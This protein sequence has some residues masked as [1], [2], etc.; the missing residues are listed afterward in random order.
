MELAVDFFAGVL[1]SFSLSRRWC[2]PLASVKSRS[3]ISSG[4]YPFDDPDCGHYPAAWKQKAGQNCLC[5]HTD[6][7]TWISYRHIKPEI[8]PDK[9]RSC[10]KNMAC[11]QLKKD[12][13]KTA[14]VF[15]SLATGLSVFLVLIA[16][17]E[18][19]GS[20]DHCIELH[21]CRYGDCQ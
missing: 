21:G 6:G 7:G 1:T 18:S 9:K 10:V 2:V 5:R 12:K 16:L 14:V 4:N 13:K 19:Q 8:A 3:G 15:L 20:K 17:I 11:R